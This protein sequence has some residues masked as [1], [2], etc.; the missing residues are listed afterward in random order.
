MPP[1][2]DDFVSF[3]DTEDG[4]TEVQVGKPEKSAS[5]DSDARLARA[6]AEQ[7]EL[8]GQLGYL[9]GALHQQPNQQQSDPYASELDA[10][11]Q[12]ERALGIEFEALRASKGLTKPVIDDFDTKARNLQQRRADVA[13]Q[14]AVQSVVPQLINAQ[15]QNHFKT[16]YSDV[17]GNESALL[18]AKSRYDMLRAM[19]ETDSPQL[20][21]KAMNDARIQFKLSGGNKMSPT[22]QDK[23]QLSGVGG[24]GGRSTNTNTV[25]MG[26]P[27]KS[28]AMAMYKDVTGGDEKKAYAM[29][30]KNVGIKA[31][32]EIAKGRR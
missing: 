25:K 2:E 26:K 8:R 12:Q 18:Y 5:N 11:T 10:I 20:V 21:D 16:K 29:W 3:V 28:M 4:E 7:A 24:G 14:R 31:A 9:Q 6:E 17:H 13:A 22:D 15:Q 23:R 32:K 1:E 30:A 27:E 19:G